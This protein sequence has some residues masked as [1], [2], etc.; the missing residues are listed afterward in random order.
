M[1]EHQDYQTIPDDQFE[2]L[3]TKLHIKEKWRPMVSYLVSLGLTTK[4]QYIHRLGRTARA[5]KGGKGLLLLA[6]FE[7][8]AMASELRTLPIKNSTV[9]LSPNDPSVNPVADAL[10]RVYQ[11]SES[12]SE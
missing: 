8:R 3:S 11:V 9:V 7:A 10:N 6:D 4:E 12:V 5:G 2:T 1:M